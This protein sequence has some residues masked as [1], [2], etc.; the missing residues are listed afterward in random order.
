V[1]E[2]AVGVPEE[3]HHGE[4]HDVLVGRRRDVDE[5]RRSRHGRRLPPRMTF[6]WWASSLLGNMMSSM[7]PLALVELGVIW[8]HA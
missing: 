1:P 6:L 8:L 5:V 2:S 7:K 3:L 4:Q